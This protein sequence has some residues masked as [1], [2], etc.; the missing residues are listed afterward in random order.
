MNNAVTNPDSKYVIELSA[1]LESGP[2]CL[3][4][5]IQ[6][7]EVIITDNGKPVA[8][9]CRLPFKHKGIP[10]TPDRLGDRGGVWGWY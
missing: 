6:D 1:L 7:K 4:K 3:D 2:K 9:I 8:I 10:C 5:V